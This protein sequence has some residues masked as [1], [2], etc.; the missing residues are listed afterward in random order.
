VATSEIRSQLLP[1]LMKNG[2]IS[3]EITDTRNGIRYSAEW[4][5]IC[6]DNG[7]P[8]PLELLDAIDRCE[9]G[10]NYEGLY[11]RM[12]GGSEQAA[13]DDYI[14]LAV[15]SERHAKSIMLHGQKN[16]WVFNNE[17]PNKFR[18]KAWFGRFPGFVAHIYNCAGK[19]PN[20]G[21][22][23]LWCLSI[24]WA[25]L[26][27]RR[28][29]PDGWMLSAH[30]IRGI[31]NARPS[32]LEITVSKFWFKRMYKKLGENGLKT[33]LLEYYCDNP[34][35]PTAKFWKWPR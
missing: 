20:L 21:Y 35:H 22:R 31:K 13:A 23:L 5:M 6:K 9:V 34:V 4:I 11:H 32:E 17:S 2:L 25:A 3:S 16:R 7:W 28:N 14:P 29:D 30:L 26:F 27:T 18:W 12:P 1:F 24:F 15:V 8:V 10:K 33:V 19:T